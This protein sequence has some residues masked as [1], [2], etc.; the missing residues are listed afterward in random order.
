MHNNGIV[1]VVP[2]QIYMHQ[3]TGKIMSRVR[4]LML[5]GVTL[6]REGRLRRMNCK[7]P[8]LFQGRP[9]RALGDA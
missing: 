9:V 5:S 3:D 6:Q 4:N 8:S 7:T 1:E 2:W